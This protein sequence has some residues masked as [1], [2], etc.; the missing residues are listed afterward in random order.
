MSVLCQVHVNLVLVD[1]VHKLVSRGSCLAMF[2]PE[3]LALGLMFLSGFGIGQL[4]VCLL[5]RGILVIVCH[6]FVVFWAGVH[7]SDSEKE[8]LHVK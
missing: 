4:N 2:G 5:R 3:P 8:S 1:T 6:G 7:C